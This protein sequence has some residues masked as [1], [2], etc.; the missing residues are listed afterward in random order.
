[1][2][3]ATLHADLLLQ[4]P[5]IWQYLLERQKQIANL[6]APVHEEDDVVAGDVL[7]GDVG[8]VVPHS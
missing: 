4:L 2:S 6:R 5:L 1:M 7:E 3:A 8:E